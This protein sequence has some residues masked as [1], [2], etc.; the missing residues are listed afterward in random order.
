MPNGVP[1]SRVGGNLH[2]RFAEGRVDRPIRGVALSPTL[3][4]RRYHG[5]E[6]T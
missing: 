6:C 3:P 5:K 1:Q 2:V 4:L